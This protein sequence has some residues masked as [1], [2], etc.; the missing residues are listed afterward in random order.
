MH[1]AGAAAGQAI[2]DRRF[3][4]KRAT[5]EAH[6]RVEEIVQWAIALRHA[7]ASTYG[8]TVMAPESMKS[9]PIVR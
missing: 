4:L 9:V 2:G 3:A 6:T 1:L 7:R 8:D 5:D